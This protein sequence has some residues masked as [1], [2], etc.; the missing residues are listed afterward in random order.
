MEALEKDGIHF[1]CGRWPLDAGRSTLVF[2]HGSAGSSLLWRAQVDG[3]AARANTVALDLPGHGQSGGSGL[4]RVADYARALT[5]FLVA[6]NAPGPIPC[7]LSLGGAIAQQ[8]LI[9][10]ADRFKA[11]ILIGTGARLR[12]MPEILEAVR[13]DFPKFVAMVDQYSF[14]AKT[15][16]ARKAASLSDLRAASAEVAY[17]DFSACDR[18]DVMAQLSVIRVPVLVVSAS[19]DQ[20]TPPKYADF[21]EA[22]IPQA[23]RARIA[24]AGH[25]AP[26]E[27][28]AEVN[29]AIHDFLDANQL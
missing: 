17:G 8:L 1:I 4:S 18:F 7:G 20:L 11:G 19:D 22:N 15:P 10:S 6:I 24:D 5:A 28:P 27:K 3:L 12:V 13:T 23:S 29:R 25:M 9:D 14:S 21:L 26:V 16:P 2:I